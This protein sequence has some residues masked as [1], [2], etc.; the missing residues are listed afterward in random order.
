MQTGA[1]W[2]AGC[3]QKA[4]KGPPSFWQLLG[5]FF[6]T[7]FSL[8]NR[9]FRSL[10]ALVIPGRLTNY[11]LAGK[12]KPYFHPLRLFFVSGV[13]MVAA[14]SF[15]AAQEVG[16]RLEQS[17]EN[18]RSNAYQH[19]FGEDL[20]IGID[21]IKAS[22]LGDTSVITASDSLL[23]LLGHSNLTNPDSFFIGFIEHQGG[24]NFKPRQ[25]GLLFDDFQIL[26]PEDLVI[27]HEITGTFSQYQFKQFV[28][29]SRLSVSGMTALISQSI[30]GL[31][32][33]APLT[34][35]LLKILYIRRKR[36]YIE[37]FIFTLHIHA[38]LFLTQFLA[39]LGLLIFE[40][41]WLL[42]IS[43]V[44][45]V[46]Y[47]LFALKR[48]YGQGW[49]K[50]LFK[51]ALLGWGYIFLFSFALVITSVVALLFF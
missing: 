16:A 23:N 21:S 14:Y 48:V 45:I 17:L 39:A 18:R 35:I 43:S 33:L 5:D 22:F 30:W 28:R 51:A 3:G 44:A 20:R 26:P 7:V 49:G 42:I 27:E 25:V 19:R 13:I 2:C 32:L 11:F 29:V 4:Y 10:A 6:E 47:F 41:P 8:D 31:L 50:T 38:F 1:N 34:A 40:T 24:F 9:F 15:Y 12:Q 36:P 46:V 37:H